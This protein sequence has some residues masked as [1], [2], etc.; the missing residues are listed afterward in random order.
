MKLIVLALLTACTF[1]PE[2]VPP[3][4]GGS[5]G[6]EGV[7]MDSRGL[8]AVV[9]DAAGTCGHDPDCLIPQTCCDLPTHTCIHGIIIAATCTAN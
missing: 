6:G 1:Q 4:D 9:P 7:R 8:D 3:L 2:R 5:S